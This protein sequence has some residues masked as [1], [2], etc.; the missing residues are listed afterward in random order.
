LDVNTE[1]YKSDIDYKC[2]I[3]PTL[4]E[5]VRNSKPFAK[6]IDFD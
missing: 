4:A 6:V 3:I 5:L 2:I 1:E